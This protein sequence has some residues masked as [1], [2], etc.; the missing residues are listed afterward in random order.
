MNGIKWIT[1]Q[2]FW[3]C[4]LS[5][6]SISASANSA[7]PFVTITHTPPKNFQLPT[8]PQ[9]THADIYFLGEYL[10]TSLISINPNN[11]ISILN[12]EQL[13]ANMPGIVNRQAIVKA[14][15]G[16]LANNSTLSRKHE[17]EKSFAILNPNTASVI[18]NPKTLKI[19]VFVNAEYLERAKR[20]NI[21]LLEKPNNSFSLVNKFNSTVAGPQ[22]NNDFNLNNHTILAYHDINLSMLSNYFRHL[23]NTGNPD[24]KNNN[25]QV[26]QL[27]GSLQ[28]W[29][30]IIETGMV[31]SNGDA[32]LETEN[33]LGAKMS[34][35]LNQIKNL[36]SVRGTPISIF[37]PTPSLVEVFKDGRLIYSGRYNPGNHFLNTSSF[38]SGA[39]NI[40]VKITGVNNN[41]RELSRFF[42]KNPSFPPIE[43][44]QYY[45]DSGYLGKIEDNTE[46]YPL[47]QEYSHIIFS[48]AGGSIRLTPTWA[49]SE[50]FITSPI[51]TASE[52]NL[53]WL[54][55]QEDIKLSLLVT[56]KQDYGTG[57]EYNT[58]WKNLNAGTGINRIWGSHFSRQKKESNNDNIRPESY[59]LISSN[60][61][62]FDSFFDFSLGKATINANLDIVQ[63]FNQAFNR[64]YSL[65]LSYPLYDNT[66]LDVNTL[67][68]ISYSNGDK[69]AFFNLSFAFKHGNWSHTLIGGTQHEQFEKT[70][71]QGQKNN[72]TGQIN[73]N[74]LWSKKVAGSYQAA[75]SANGTN[76]SDYRQLAGSSY[77]S[78]NDVLFD[79]DVTRNLPRTRG[80][81]DSTQYNG[82]FNTSLIIAENDF[83][84][85]NTEKGDTGLL[86]DIESPSSTDKF[87]VLIN[88]E[89][90]Q[91]INANEP[92]FIYV[93]PYQQYRISIHSLAKNYYGYNQQARTVTLY[94]NGVKY[95]QWKMQPQYSFI[96]TL[97][98]KNGDPIKNAE[99]VINGKTALTNAEGVLHVATLL[100]TKQLIIK[101]NNGD[102]CTINLANKKPKHDYIYQEKTIC[103]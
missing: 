77:L 5:S 50:N 68:S 20:K 100:K 36:G 87:E 71:N 56:N 64:N 79:L 96:T 17:P 31:K 44:P 66:H 49:A 4:L 91:V 43:H 97:I 62:A 7:K 34:S 10:Q 40:S 11:T 78:N 70:N 57:I 52:T 73:V 9:E 48:Q 23:S 28:R 29:G 81:K 94:Q 85:E 39:Y 51:L 47:F 18:F 16:P 88:S 95:L 41:T 1:A 60:K 3:I 83:G 72:T 38:P 99:L 13:V 19:S 12:P 37:L 35:N 63:Q 61:Y 103:E 21:S 42:S 65:N 30:R 90:V 69:T 75:F 33:V 86:V 8:G 46:S 14:L 98:K 80:D 54:R 89:P 84:F 92:T 76:D 45:F 67:A 102:Q 74:N 101:Q 15:T 26:Q 58:S 59:N 32:F 55:H 93:E 27:Y 6:I 24:K 25:Y 82:K 2:S 22:N 53:T